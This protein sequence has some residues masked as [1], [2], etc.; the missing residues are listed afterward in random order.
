ML[1]FENPS[2]DPFYNQA[3]EEYVFNTYRDEDIF[4]V[5]QN[6]PAV[7]VGCSQ[8][9]CREVKVPLLQQLGIPVIRRMTGGG[10]VYHDAGNLN[11]TLIRTLPPDGL[12]DYDKC[13][14]P[15]IGALNDMG[16]PARKNRTCDIAIGEEKISGS[17]QK[18]QKGRI[19]HHGTLLFDTDLSVLDEVT[20]A[21]KNQ[22]FQSRGTESAICPVTNI[23]AHLVRD[24]TFDQFREQLTGRVLP[25]GS[26]AVTL[27]PEQQAE[28][29]RLSAAKYHSWEWTWGRTPPF[30]Y[31]R[32]GIFQ[33]QPIEV[34]YAARRGILSDVAIASPLFDGARAAAALEGSRL[35]PDSF[36]T[37]CQSLVGGAARELLDFLL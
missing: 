24:M 32:K 28:V 21:W 2:R 37:L 15:V 25:P 3:F 23:R 36:L 9:I 14:A 16:I 13:L 22:A 19:L 6:R 17:A 27:S 8:N 34:A 33:G 20:T 31:Q 29:S 11:Y 12:L 26:P 4:F 18:I 7:I 30:Q 5:W 10:T 35:D 1:T